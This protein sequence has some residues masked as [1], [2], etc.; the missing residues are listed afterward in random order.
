MDLKS[1]LLIQADAYCEEAGISLA[2]LATIVANDGK[3]FVRLQSGGG[4]T[5][6]MYE[7]F[8]A[9]FREHPAAE[10]GAHPTP[11]PKEAA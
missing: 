7:R 3:F 11:T 4:L 9:Y 8:M 10:R 1:E 5:V 2:R 6:R